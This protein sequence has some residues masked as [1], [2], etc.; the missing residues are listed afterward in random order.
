MEFKITK[1]EPVAVKFNYEEIKKELV[2][3]VDIF[4]HIV[5]TN[6]TI[7]TAKTDRSE[8]NK[9]KKALNDKRIEVQKEYMKPFDTF[10][11][12][13]DELIDYVNESIENV[14]MQVKDYEARAKVEKEAACRAKFTEKNRFDWLTY[15]KVSNA[16]WLLVST[17]MSSVE[18][19]MV[20]T[21]NGIEAILNAL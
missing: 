12:Q 19:D 4:K 5:Y 17:S 15:E 8:L 10:K 14:D 1:F 21:L 16:K 18:E 20:F 2:E 7:K 11:G 6:E 9:V 13:V 3:K